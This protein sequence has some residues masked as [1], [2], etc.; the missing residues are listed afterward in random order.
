MNIYSC[1]AGNTSDTSNIAKTFA[2]TQGTTVNAFDGGVSFTDNYNPRTSSVWSQ[3]EYMW[4]NRRAPIGGIQYESDGNYSVNGIG[5]NHIWNY[6]YAGINLR[7]A[8]FHFFREYI[9]H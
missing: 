3:L 6:V 1:Q 5:G 2:M 9:F 7:Y 4:N 8:P